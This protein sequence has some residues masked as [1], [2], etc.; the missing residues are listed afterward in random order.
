VKVRRQEAR[1]KGK[2]GENQFAG[3]DNIFGYLQST[4]MMYGADNE[5]ELYLEEEAQVNILIQRSKTQAGDRGEE[6][7]ATAS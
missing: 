7:T 6:D 1:G 3:R 4:K 5:L 2:V